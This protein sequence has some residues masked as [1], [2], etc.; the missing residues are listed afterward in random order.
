MSSLRRAAL[1][2]VP[3]CSM[4]VLRNRCYQSAGRTGDCAFGGTARPANC[5]CGACC[6]VRSLWSLT[7]DAVIDLITAV[8][9]FAQN[10]EFS[11]EC[12]FVGDQSYWLS[13][14]LIDT[15]S[16]SLTLASVPFTMT[17]KKEVTSLRTEY[18]HPT[19]GGMGHPAP[20]VRS[21]PVRS[22]ALDAC[23]RRSRTAGL[24]LAPAALRSGGR[25]VWRGFSSR[26]CL[27]EMTAVVGCD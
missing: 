1:D 11:D 26:T 6:G 14:A 3:G 12:Q 8:L 5:A 20:V 16:R 17:R 7:L 25:S 27:V 23:F 21:A 18:T 13:G 4:S 24:S 19:W 2:R 22:L 9:R 15:Y 10:D